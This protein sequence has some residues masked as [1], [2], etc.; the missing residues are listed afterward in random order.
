MNHELDKNQLSEDVRKVV[1][2]SSPAFVFVA[3]AQMTGFMVYCYEPTCLFGRSIFS[4]FAV[5]M[6]AL[7]FW[8]GSW[9]AIGAVRAFGLAAADRYLVCNSGD[10]TNSSETVDGDTE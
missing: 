1:L 9:M 3:W 6:F 7:L 5:V 8:L 2:W 4:W 10:S